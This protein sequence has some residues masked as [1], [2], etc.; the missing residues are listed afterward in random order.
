[1]E[2]IKAAA[3]DIG[4]N[5]IRYMGKGQKRLITTRLAEGLINTG[6]LSDAA[7]ARSIAA[8]NEFAALAK[9]EGLVPYA[10]ATSAVRDAE[11]VSQGHFLAAAREIMPVRVL[12]G[13]EEA[14]FALIGAGIDKND[15]AA[16]IDVG[17]GSC[18]LVSN[19]FGTSAPMGCVRAKDVCAN[20]KK[21]DFEGL[22]AAVFSACSGLFRFPRIR[23]KDWTGVGGTITTLCAY[24]MGLEKYDAH[25]LKNFRLSRSAAQAI[26]K[27]LFYMD[28]DLRK[29][30]PLLTKR[31][32]VIVPGTFVLLYAMEGMGIKELR[33]SDSDGM[34]GFFYMLNA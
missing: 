24:A 9:Q 25:A 8:L 14:R 28:E 33:P 16:L 20:C 1:M 29:R 3:V 11:P 32:D 17:G 31:H 18:Q 4:S 6:R 34:D 7:M 12:G 5:S 30:H 15:N 22:K 26:A 27:E 19:A 23:I 21:E 2:N 13:E 10:Y